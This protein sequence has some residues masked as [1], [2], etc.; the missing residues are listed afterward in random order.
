MGD[1]FPTYPSVLKGRLIERRP[2]SG[3][4]NMFDGS[5]SLDYGELADEASLEDA[6]FYET[7]THGFSVG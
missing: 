6:I 4:R 7:H 2:I 3:N 5:E 1:D